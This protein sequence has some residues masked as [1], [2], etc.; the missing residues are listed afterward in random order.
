MSEP[1]EPKKIEP[2]KSEKKTDY[3]EQAKSFLT[4]DQ[5]FKLKGWIIVVLAIILLALIFD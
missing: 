2:S 3:I 1:Q 4:T 5:I